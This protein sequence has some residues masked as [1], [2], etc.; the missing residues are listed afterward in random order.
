MNTCLS[1]GTPSVA[2]VIDFGRHALCNRFLETATATEETVPLGM[3]A[4][5]RCGVVQIL[6]PSSP[7]SLKPH[8]P[9]ITC[10]EPEG[11]LDDLAATIARLPGLPAE[12]TICGV[13]SKDDSLLRRLEYLRPFRTWRIDPNKDLGIQDPCA[14]IETMQA[15]LTP[16][17]AEAMVSRQ[18]LSDI[19]IARHVF[20]HAS[21]PTTFAMALKQ[22]VT[23]GG[24]VVI[25]VPDCQ[26]A[27]DAFDYTTI[28]EEHSL[29]LTPPTFHRVLQEQGF[30]VQHS[31]CIPYALENSLIAI[32]A[33]ASGSQTSCLD[34]QLVSVDVEV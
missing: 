22:L 5:H 31:L 12:A 23:S 30:T 33:V 4:C 10:T 19:V 1:C 20:E 25:E 9:W 18:G 16:A 24:Y 3:G 17:R 26:K 28:W 29:Y 27:L 15:H 14:G 6:E 21:S 2:P 11:H 7:E 13:S 32:T 34:E 8:V